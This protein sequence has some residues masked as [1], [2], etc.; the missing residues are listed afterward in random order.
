MSRQA[1]ESTFWPSLTFGPINLWSF[2]ANWR[3]EGSQA[4]WALRPTPAPVSVAGE[5]K[6]LV[7]P[8]IR[9]VL[10]HR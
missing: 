6:A 5:S 3:R 4:T 10:N 2:P 7:H 1:N 8:M 9:A